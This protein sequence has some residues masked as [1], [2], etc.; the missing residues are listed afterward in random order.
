MEM[1]SARGDRGVCGNLLMELYNVQRIW[2]SV[3]RIPSTSGQ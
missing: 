3:F 1:W 2:V